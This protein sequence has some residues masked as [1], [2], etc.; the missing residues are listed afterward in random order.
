MNIEELDYNLPEELIAQSP[1]YERDASRLLHIDRRTGAIHHRLFRDCVD[2][3][4]PGDLL[5]MNNTRV[6]AMRLFGQKPTG[7]HVEALLLQEL[8]EGEFL[9]LLKPTKRL[10][11][12]THIWFEGGLLAK[13][14]G[15]AAAGQRFI[16]FDQSPDWRETLE[17]VSL[18]PLPPYIK[19]KLADR[20][21]YQTVIAGPGGSAAAPTAGLHFTQ[22][23]LDTLV[24]K[25]VA[26]AEVTLHVGLDTFRPI[27]SDRIENHQMVGETCEIL[28]KTAEAV[29]KCRG[30][31]VAVG[32]T[33]VR[34][35]ETFATGKNTVVPGRTSSQLF[36]TPGYDFKIVD[37]MFT[38]FHMPRTSMLLMI[39]AL[40]GAKTIQTAYNLA[41]EERYRFLSFGDSMLIL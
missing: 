8:A 34:T 33:T 20:G 29:A 41:V 40:A 38:N 32:T 10:P 17:S 14:S 31:I 39:S 9:C 24:K 36:I 30:R 23:I 11:I 3:L 19:T 22:P 13:V 37:G 28:P 27:Q 5:V 16:Q 4:D 18:A 2:L 1:L 35:L 12:G 25:G 26:L 21:R 15:E 7:G 6:T